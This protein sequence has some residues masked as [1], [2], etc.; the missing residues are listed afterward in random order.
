MMKV[1]GRCHC[2]H[3]KFE[4]E[5][6]ESEVVICHCRDCQILAGSAFSVSVPAKAETFRFLQG[7]PAFYIKTAESGNRRRH[8]FCPRCG[9]RVLACAADGE[10][11]FFGLRVG[12][13]TQRDQLIPSEQIWTRSAQRWLDRIGELQACETE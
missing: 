5:V 11:G 8:A 1:D 2:G 10:A 13:L 3:L 9:T 4:A 7:E 6:D 12:P